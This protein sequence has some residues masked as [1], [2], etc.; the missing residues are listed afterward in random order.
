MNKSSAQTSFCICLR[1]IS[2]KQD[3]LVASAQ[4][5]ISRAMDRRGG[6]VAWPPR[7]PNL[8]PLDFFFWGHMKS[9]VYETRV[10]SAEDLVA[11]IVVTADKVL[12]VRFFLYRKPFPIA[13]LPR[14]HNQTKTVPL[15]RN[16]QP[17]N[18]VLIRNKAR[19]AVSFRGD[20][21]S[22]FHSFAAVAPVHALRTSNSSAHSMREGFGVEKGYI[23][24]SRIRE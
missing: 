8:N 6:P 24:M 2:P 1:S 9:L 13:S 3:G 21:G 4:A 7:S 14:R 5:Y 16:K 17:R 18:P 11:R 15:P 12:Q 19:S 22:C 23:C 10:D 20:L